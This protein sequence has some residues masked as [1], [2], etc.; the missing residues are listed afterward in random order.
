MSLRGVL[1]WGIG[2]V[3]VTA[4]VVW[5]QVRRS[6]D[7]VVAFADGSD[8]AAVPAVERTIGEPLFED[9]SKSAGVD[10]TYR[11]GEESDLY[12]ILESLGGGVALIDYDGDG[13]LDI[14]LTGGGKF[15]SRTA[16]GIEGLPGRLY[17]N[18][19]Q[20][21]FRDVTIESGMSKAGMYSH[22]AVVVDWNQDGRPDLLVSG[23]GGLELYQ[24]E[25]GRRFHAVTGEA[26]LTDGRW[27]TS[28]GVGDLWGAGRPDL[29][30][31]RYVDWSF[32]HDPVCP[33]RGQSEGRDVCAPQ[34]FAAVP[35][36]IYSLE[37]G[38]YRDHWEQ[39]KPATEGKSLGVVI[40]DVNADGRPDVYVAN[41][42]SPNWLFLNEGNGQL[43]ECGRVL[44]VSVDDSG[45]YNGSMGVDASDFDGSGLASLWVTNFESELPALYRNA[46]AGGFAYA[47]QSAGL[48][49]LGGR[50]V[51]FG[52]S[53]LDY[54]NDG[55]EDLVFVNGH[56]VRHPVGAD[57][58]QRPVLL[59]N[60]EKHGRRM[61]ADETPRGGHWFEQT[62][63]G[64][65]LATGDLDNDGWP[66]LVISHSNSPVAVLRN[67]A[68]VS[69][70]GVGKRHW[71]GLQL[72]G[73]GHRPLAGAT[74]TVQTG[75][76]QVTRFLRG[77][78]SYLSSGDSRV[79]IGLGESE[80][81]K[82]ISVRWPWGQE[83]R[84]DIAGV[85]RYWLLLEGEAKAADATGA[86]IGF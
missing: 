5:Y 48:G 57:V 43:R 21:K 71:L 60:T 80:S 42:A 55:W 52:T 3:V 29:F 65:G 8:G 26:G 27:S 31:C 84:W 4:A 50:N 14:Y 34:N 11:N 17:R 45:R 53:F 69:S 61:F 36:S 18:L 86:A 41:D 59:R 7:P 79:L 82:G 2:C 38:V 23:Y 66:D 63:L 15:T 28:V 62:A 25:D 20:L 51:G 56:V 83:Q 22:G 37:G 76:R 30:V 40:V 68:G 47:S 39:L 35:S 16:H 77:G 24:N 70:M 58:R 10:F 75:D 13:L 78:G 1:I 72:Q 44:G 6:Q 73:R 12:T 67:R 19:G 85:D 54:D 64:R 9:V 46:G 33:L 32:E 49:R 74:I 81:V